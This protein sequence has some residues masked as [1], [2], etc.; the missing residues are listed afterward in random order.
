MYEVDVGEIPNGSKEGAS[1]YGADL[2]QMPEMDMQS[3]N[4]HLMMMDG[5]NMN[6][7]RLRNKSMSLKNFRAPVRKKYSRKSKLKLSPI[8]LARQSHPAHYTD[9]EKQILAGLNNRIWINEI[10]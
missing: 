9:E 4:D 10:S 3:Y 1:S 8:K 2:Q 5:I 7:P 6:K